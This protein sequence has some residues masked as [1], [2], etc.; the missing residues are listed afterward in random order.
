M[1][2]IFIHTYIYFR[3]K[4]SNH[5]TVRGVISELILSNTNSD[6][7]GHYQCEAANP[8]GNAQQVILLIVQ[9]ITFISLFNIQYVFFVICI[10]IFMF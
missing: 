6:D 5:Q 4:I 1:L 10:I 8:H 2:S 7:A 3:S 9:G